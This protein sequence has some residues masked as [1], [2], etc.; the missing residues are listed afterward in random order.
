MPT[1]AFAERVR[2]HATFA[3]Q[4]HQSLGMDAEKLGALFSIDIR[5]R[6]RIGLVGK[7]R[8]ASPRVAQDFRGLLGVN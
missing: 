7:E 4:T 5:L 6:A 1:S 2:R 8:V 3:R